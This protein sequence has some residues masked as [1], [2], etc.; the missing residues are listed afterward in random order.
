MLKNANQSINQ[1]NNEIRF[2]KFAE[3]AGVRM[4]ADSVF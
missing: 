4:S 3:I 1:S 2:F